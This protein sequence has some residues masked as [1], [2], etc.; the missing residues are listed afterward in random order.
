MPATDAVFQSDRGTDRAGARIR[1]SRA[2]VAG[3]RGCGREP[4]GTEP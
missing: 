2:P 4:E 3:G 1:A